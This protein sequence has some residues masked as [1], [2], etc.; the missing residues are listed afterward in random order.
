MEWLYTHPDKPAVQ[1]S[2]VR[3]VYQQ[4]DGL[5]CVEPVNDVIHQALYRRQ[6]RRANPALYV[7]HRDVCP[8]QQ[9][10]QTKMRGRR[11]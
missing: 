3:R 7:Q 9:T 6:G 2:M 4:P 10:M 1:V 8:A 5:G 11:E